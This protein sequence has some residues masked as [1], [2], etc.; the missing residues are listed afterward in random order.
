LGPELETTVLK[1]ARDA[2][3]EHPNQFAGLVWDGCRGQLVAKYKTGEREADLDKLLQHYSSG[4][5]RSG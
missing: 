2:M 3:R 4:I 5:T 1:A